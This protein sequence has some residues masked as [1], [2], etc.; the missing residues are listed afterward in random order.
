MGFNASNERNVS[1]HGGVGWWGLKT[2]ILIVNLDLSVKGHWKIM[3]QH[4]ETITL[5]FK[6]INKKCF[7]W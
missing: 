3:I 1:K 4:L 7:V 2:M 6:V 5:Y